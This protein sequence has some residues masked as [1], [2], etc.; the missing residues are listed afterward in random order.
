MHSIICRKIIHGALIGRI[1]IV[2]VSFPSKVSTYQDENTKRNSNVTLIVCIKHVGYMTQ[3]G[4][5]I[6]VLCNAVMTCIGYG[7]CEANI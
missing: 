2:L 4:P 1:G 7:L 5:M 3:L 6:S